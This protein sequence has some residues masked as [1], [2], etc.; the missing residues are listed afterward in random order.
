MMR[1][2]FDEL[3][4][5]TVVRLPAPPNGAAQA[6]VAFDE[7]LALTAPLPLPLLP[8]WER[9]LRHAWWHARHHHSRAAASARAPRWLARLPF[10]RARPEAAACVFPPWLAL[11]SGDG[12][13]REGALRALAGPAPNRFFFALALRRLNDWVPQVRAAARATLV[14]LA[15]ASDPDHVVDA[16]C[17]VLPAWTSWGRLQAPERALM[18]TL[19][20]LD[21][22]NAAL[23]RR[24]LSATHGPLASALTQCLRTAALDPHLSAIAARAVQPAVRAAAYRALLSGRAVWLEGHEREWIDLRYC[25]SRMRPILGERPLDHAPPFLQ[26][27]AAAAADRAFRVRRVAAQALVIEMDRLAPDVLTEWARR[28][29]GDRSPCVAQR[30]AFILERLAAAR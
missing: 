7:L 15:Q 30:G 4:C 29:A 20:A 13:E 12:H 21:G 8:E 26:T 5:A 22:V 24:L 6:R 9:R 11:V 14:P 25:V 18:A 2:A 17:A 28:F 3:L 10:A 19:I 16:L 1:D 27:L 23:V